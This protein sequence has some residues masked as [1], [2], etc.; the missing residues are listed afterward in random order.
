MVRT[1]RSFED[2]DAAA[3][4]QTASLAALAVILA[5]V[6]GGLYLVQTLRNAAD[7]QDCLMS[8]QRFCF[9]TYAQN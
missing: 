3:N 1:L 2:P 4:R 7:L 6:V 9:A 5:L 8:G